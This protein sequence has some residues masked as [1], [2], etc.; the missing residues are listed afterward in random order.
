MSLLSF[1]DTV[2]DTAQ[3]SKRTGG[4]TELFKNE[5]AYKY[6]TLRYPLDVGNSDKGHYMLI[7]I[8]AQKKSEY[9]AGTNFLEN[10]DPTYVRN[11]KEIIQK[12]GQVN[13]GGAFSTG[14]NLTSGAVSSATQSLTQNF[15]TLTQYATNITSQINSFATSQLPGTTESVKQAVSGLGSATSQA[16]KNVNGE[17]FLRTVS[18]TTDAIALYMPDTLTFEYNQSYS[19]LSLSK[20]VTGGLAAAGQAAVDSYSRGGANGFKNIGQNLAPFVASYA[21][22]GFGDFGKALVAGGFGVV[23]NPMIEMLYTQPNLRNFQFDFMFYPRDEKEAFEVQKILDK[24]RYHQAPEIKNE[25]G[26]YFL[27]PPSEFDISFYYN[28]KVNPNIDRI[29]TCVLE[30][31]VV[32]YAPSGFSAYESLYENSPSMG[33][34]GMPVA[35]QL[36]LMFKETQIMTKDIYAY[37]NRAGL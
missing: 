13:F 22:G 30:K 33:R 15:P 29:S 20:G 37:I 18:R 11:M 6:E 26:G 17:N 14:V 7:H 21:L 4:P 12:R 2:Y 3:N 8:N 35:I 25:S 24:L 31:V 10:V 36:T 32:N 5:K 16:I 28:G 23:Q 1:L 27:I 9:A 19:E 34:T